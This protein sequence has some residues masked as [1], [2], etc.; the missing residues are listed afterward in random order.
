IGYGGSCF[1]KDVKALIQTYNEYGIESDILKA[2]DH[3]NKSQRD[4]F[5]K[6]ILSH[7]NN[8]LKNLTFAVWGLS[9][10]PQTD[11]MREAPSIDII[12]GLRDQGAK[13]KAYDPVAVEV[14]KSILGNDKI[15]Y[16]SHYYDTLKDT[17]AL[18]LLTEWHQFREPDFNRMKSLMK[19]PVIFDGRNQYDMEKIKEKG[20]IYYCVGRK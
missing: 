5:I 16:F 7:F 14:S 1:P 20:F 3:V 17:D 15:E 2:V 19:S 11:D 6:K 13:F 10:K 12:N 8:N 18:L 9:F 4:I